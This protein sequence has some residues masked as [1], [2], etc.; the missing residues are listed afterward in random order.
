MKS[1]KIGLLFL[2]LALAL[3]AC[4]GSEN[5][6]KSE[7]GQTQASNS[8]IMKS[9]KQLNL[10]GDWRQTNSKSKE[11]YME[12]TISD[13][14]IV[15]N[16]VLDNGDTKALYWYGSFENPDTAEDEYT[17]TSKQ[18]HEKMDGA[19]LASQDETKNFQYKDGELSYTASMMGITTTVRMKRK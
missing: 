11:D 5:E 17:W 7:I 18:N 14:T 1:K 16:W 13:D 2:A 8:E 10:N 3:T 19:L 12:A 6:A 9:K 4:G 15:I